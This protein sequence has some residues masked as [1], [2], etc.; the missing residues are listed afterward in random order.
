MGEMRE[1]ENPDTDS[2]DR[3]TR[4]KRGKWYLISSGKKY[5]K[6]GEETAPK[7]FNDG[8]IAFLVT[9]SIRAIVIYSIFCCCM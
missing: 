7:A 2:E 8:F 1:G 6:K 3:K 4:E 5:R 9:P